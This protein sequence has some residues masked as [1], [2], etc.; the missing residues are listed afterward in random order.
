MIRGILRA[1]LAALTGAS[2]LVGSNLA[3]AL[4]A[5]GVKVRATRR[6]G[7]RTDH[8]EGHG[9]EWVDGDLSDEAA[10]TRAFTGA[11]VVFHCAAAVS[12]RKEPTPALV[13]TNVD[14]TRHVLSAV[15]AAGAGR[16]VHCS[17]VSAV[18]LSTDGQPCTEAS[19]WNFADYGLADGYSTTKHKSEELVREAAAAGLDAVIVNPTYMF[20]PYDAR[21]S[22]GQMLLEIARRRVPSL[23]PGYNNFVDVR[24]VARGMLLAWRK[25]QKGERYILGGH[26]M[27]YAEITQLVARL[28]GV[29][30]PRLQL[31]RPLVKLVGLA[32]DFVE[33]FGKEPFI[34]STV[35][36]YGYTDRFQ[37]SS[38][39]AERELGYTYGPLEP[40]IRDALAWFKQRN[41]L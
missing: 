38:A 18:G 33:L 12:I 4:L 7:T 26:K 21:P 2:G 27:S 41:M 15:R 13:S 32:G 23:I 16:L 29:P 36:A 39:R 22:S 19:P 35:V 20:G 24:D 14:G 37:F 25:G 6:K 5:E 40:A 10:L 17:S 31:P 28:A 1:M 3:L 34:N 9:I 8:L 11:D 30:A